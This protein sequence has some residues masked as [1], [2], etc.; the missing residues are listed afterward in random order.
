MRAKNPLSGNPSRGVILLGTLILLLTI[1]FIG[2]TLAAS[3]ASLT[4]LA[5]VELAKTQAL[6][7]AEAGVAQAFQQLH[8]AG[9]SGGEAP[10]R[11]GPVRL[12]EGQYEVIH[13]VSSRL[14]T[15]TGSVRGVRRTLQVK[16][17][18]L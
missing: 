4:S 13:D 7:L 3:F 17:L 2:A 12:D 9:L 6:Y 18:S 10:Q 1:G 5:E 16:Y 11:I 8:Q 14:I 15:V